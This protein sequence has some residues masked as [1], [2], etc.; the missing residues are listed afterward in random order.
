MADTDFNVEAF[1]EK[2]NLSVEDLSKLKKAHLR[3]IVEHANVT[4]PTSATKAGL[5][6]AI[7][8][9]LDLGER[10]AEP[11]QT[12]QSSLELEKLRLELEFKE[13]KE[14]ERKRKKEKEKKGKGK[15]KKGRR[16]ER[17]EKEREFKLKMAEIENQKEVELKKLEISATSSQNSV[18]P[19]TSARPGFDLAKNIRLVPKFDEQDVETFFSTFEK[20]AHR[21]EWPT[22]Y[23]TLMLQSVFVG[24]AQKVCSELSI[25]QSSDYEEV[26]ALVLTA[27]E[28]VPESY[29]QKF[30]NW[31]RKQGQTYV[32]YSKEKELW[33]DRWYRSLGEEKSFGRLREVILLEEFKNHIP[34]EIRTHLDEQGTTELHKAGMLADSYE[35]THRKSGSG[36]QSSRWTEGHPGKAWSKPSGDLGQRGSS[37]AVQGQSGQSGN[38]RPVRRDVE[39]FYCHAKGHVRS[40]C[41]KLR[42]GQEQ[43]RGRKPVALVKSRNVVF[44]SGNTDGHGVVTQVESA[45]LTDSRCSPDVVNTSDCTGDHC[46][47]PGCVVDTSVDVV[48]TDDRSDVSC[49]VVSH[50]GDSRVSAG[51][52]SDGDCHVESHGDSG[53]VSDMY[54]GFV[55][56]G[57]V[58]DVMDGCQKNPVTILRDTGASQSL[59]LS[60]VSPESTDGEVGAK[61]LIQGIDGGYVPVPL[62][63]VVLKSGLVS[64]VVTVGVVPSLPI[65]GVD[66]LLGNDLAGDKVSVTPVLVDAPAE[67]AET[68]ALEDEFPGIFPACVVTRSQARGAKRDL[69]ESEKTT[70]T[71]VL[72]AETFFSDLDPSTD[73]KSVLSRAALIEEQKTDPE[74]RRLRQTAMSEIE[75]NDVPEG[76]YIKDDVLMRK[77]R[78]P[79]SPASDDWSVVHQVVLPLSFRPEVL[80][81]AHEAPMAGHVG[82]RRTRSRIMA[83]FWW[84]RL[85]KDTAQFCRTCHAC[86]VVGKPQSV[87]KPVSFV[88]IPVFEEPCSKVLVGPVSRTKPRKKRKKKSRTKLKNKRRRRKR[89]GKKFKIKG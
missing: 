12:V 65:D 49:S 67:Q 52:R 62:R 66:F 18:P 89:K 35:L 25:E 70:D 41:E 28:L 32:D 19:S 1:L 40:E 39:C 6:Q 54:K 60:S 85:Y 68:E 84:P 88:P 43:S 5:V 14:R 74:V 38:S 87:V 50:G 79:R 7:S 76:F 69:D 20:Y 37:T 2:E 30:R 80:R 21:L 83:H 31:K 26:K 48:G 81:L 45:R 86:Q 27:Y 8:V 63:R 78:N 55:S 51:D 13:R 24:K 82:I 9:H 34:S 36:A 57:E 10:Q 42:R 59:M 16:R 64:G 4:V 61:A 46:D 77:W 22:E 17:E 71:G 73:T 44:Q 29:R 75:A 15:E 3:A 11:A 53:P 47:G 23:W 56:Q 58:S 33:F 72:L